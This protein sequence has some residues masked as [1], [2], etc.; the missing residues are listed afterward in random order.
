MTELKQLMD[1]NFLEYASYVI[2]DRAIPDIGDG[3]K[4]VQRRILHS[5]FEMEDGKFNKVANVVGHCMKYHPHGDMSI[6]EA[7][8]V[9]ANKGYFIE[10]QGNF[11]N[12]LT[13]DSA[14][15]ARY[16]ECRLT[17]LA[18][19]VL[20]NK[21]LTDYSPSY[22]GRNHE[23]IVFPCKLPTLLLQGAEGI[24]VGMST[25]ILPHNFQEVLQAQIAILNGKGFEIFPD[26]I[27]GGLMDV[28]QY[29]KGI[30]RIKLRAKMEF[31]NEKTIIIREIPFGQTTESLITSVENA[32]KKN[33]IQIQGISDFTSEKIE[34]EI[35]LA[36]GTRVQDT[37]KALYAYTDCE[38]SISLQCIVIKENK[39][40]ETNVE[41][42][43]LDS[44]LAL[45]EVLRKELE[46]LMRKAKDL[47]HYKMLEQIF[48]EQRIYKNIEEIETWE[49][50]LKTVKDSFE[51]YSAELLQPLVL[52]DIERLLKIPIRKIS[53]FDIE[54]SSKEIRELRKKIREYRRNLKDLVSYTIDY[55][56]NLLENYGKYYPRRTSLE[57]FSEV[58]KKEVALKNLKIRYD[59]KKHFVGTA[60][61]EGELLFEGGEY[62]RI[63]VMQKTGEFKLMQVENKIFV[64]KGLAYIQKWD[65]DAVFTVVYQDK[66]S[67]F[68]YIKRFQISK[69]ILNKT[70]RFMPEKSKLAGF[71]VEKTG[72]LR[73]KYVPK[74]RIKKEEEFYFH[75]QLVKGYAARG[76]RVSSKEIARV[77]FLK[78]TQGRGGLVSTLLSPETSDERNSTE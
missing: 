20:F 58:A 46:L 4:P 77:S 19:E 71:T 41:E 65:K 45:K 40:F 53:R 50:V 68:H 2:K 25:K 64:D 38:V 43:L 39:P 13:G 34:I 62:D 74:P 22:D 44:T 30:G 63:L 32:A 49:G 27:H 5:M 37:L 57:K 75:E 69:F 73:V 6:Y 31:P 11:G 29:E 60:V 55:L 52:E 33:K 14:S 70:Y 51:P 17:P 26:F 67:G 28:E 35:K 8:V 9:L 7:L 78:M 59:A 3:L 36:R 56:N 54:N 48:I 47:L 16:I 24:A 12:I 42:I 21:E 1:T 23:P 10:T 18:R 66:N 76:N 15:A 61:K 72:I